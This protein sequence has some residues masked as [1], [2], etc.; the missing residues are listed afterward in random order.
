MVGMLDHGNTEALAKQ[1][2]DDARQQ[3]RLAGAAPPGE[4]NHFHPHSPSRRRNRGYVLSCGALYRLTGNVMLASRMMMKIDK[5]P[6]PLI[7]PNPHDPRLTERVA[8]T[9]QTGV[10]SEEHTSELQSQS[11]LVC[12]LLLEK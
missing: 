11:N 8:G 2:R 4:A 9:D 3:R 6:V 12:R 5:A 7:V 10:R 1:M